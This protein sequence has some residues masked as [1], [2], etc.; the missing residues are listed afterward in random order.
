MT[1]LQRFKTRWLQ[2]RIAYHRH[3]A[4][5][6]SLPVVR[7]YRREHYHAWLR[8]MALRHAIKA[9]ALERKLVVAGGPI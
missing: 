2:V 3:Q 4:H 7:A 8:N 6:Y 9:N 1:A 5:S